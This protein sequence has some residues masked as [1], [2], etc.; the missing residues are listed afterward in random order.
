MDCS[1]PSFPA[2]HQVL[3]LAQTHVHQV[4]IAIQPSHPVLLP[5]SSCLQSFPA[6]WSFPVTQFFTSGGWT[7]GVFSFSISSSSEYSGL[8][9]FRVDWSDLKALVLII[10]PAFIPLRVQDAQQGIPRLST[11]GIYPAQALESRCFT[12]LVLGLFLFSSSW[13][14]LRIMWFGQL[15]NLAQKWETALC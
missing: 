13:I 8:I 4:G 14:G 6:S 11:C 10:S 3:E 5:F 1:T 9:S 12:W 7:I 15:L 2:N